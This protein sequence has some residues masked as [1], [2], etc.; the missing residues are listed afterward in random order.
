MIRDVVVGLIWK[1]YSGVLRK[2][3]MGWIFRVFESKF[4]VFSILKIRTPSFS[5]ITHRDLKPENLLYSD[6]RPDARLLITDF[7][8]AH[9]AK[10]PDEKMTETCG[11]PEVS[12][13]RVFYFLSLKLHFW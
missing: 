3:F 2:C 9:Q 1:W 5:E 6:G 10:G 8:L 7:G 12:F 13:L 4:F 11:T